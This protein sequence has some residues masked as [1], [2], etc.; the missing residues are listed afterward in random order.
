MKLLAVF[1]LTAIGCGDNVEVLPDAATFV[2][3]PLPQVIPHT[4]NVLDHPK[5]ITLTYSDHADRAMVEAWGDAVVMSSWYKAVGGQYSIGAMTHAAKFVMGPAPTTTVED[6]DVEAKIQALITA[7]SV[8]APDS[9][10]LYMIY[11]PPQVTLG[12]SL[13]DLYGYHAMLTRPT[14]ER[15]AYAVVVDDG[16]GIATTT[17]TAAHE[18]IEAATDP[19]DPPNDGW[20]TDPGSPDPWS[21]IL[22]EVADLCNT[23]PVVTEGGFTYQRSW[24]NTAAAASE[25]PCVPNTGDVYE[26]VSAEPRSMPTVAKGETVTFTLTGW[27]TAAEPDWTLDT[28]DADYSDLTA[29]QINPQLSATKINAGKTVTLTLKVPT[30]AR[31]GSTGG[32]YVLSGQ[33]QRPWAVG[34]IVQ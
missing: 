26:T 1:A 29:A 21:L 8:P 32:V 23:D 15:F 3:T 2:H 28:Y 10:T 11:L 17:A 20:Y 4:F 27:S 18:L 33:Y 6:T 25:N 24:S 14:G 31:S 9:N 34:F 22:G 7:G 16:S 19:F 13:A 30:G 5:L 12:D